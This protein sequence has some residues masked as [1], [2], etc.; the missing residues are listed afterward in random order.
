MPIQTGTH[1]IADL[2]SN[3]FAGEL[4][5]PANVDAINEAVQRDLAIHNQRVTEM[6]GQLADISTERSTAYGTSAEAEAHKKDEFTRGPTQKITRG[7]KVEFPLDAYQFAVGWTADFLRRATVQD[8]ALRTIAARQAHLKRIQQDLKE[9]LF[10]PT[11]YTYVDRR[12]DGNSLSVKRLLNADSSP[13]PTGPNGESF[14]PATHTHYQAVD[15]TAANAAAKAAALAALVQ[16]VIEHGHAAGLVI[17]ISQSNESEVRQAEDFEPLIY[18]N[19]VPGTN[20]DRAVGVLDVTRLDNRLIGYF[21]GFP[22]WTKPWVPTDY[23][24]ASAT[25]EAG[26]KPLRMRVSTL[27]SEQGLF[28]AGQI[29][30]FPLQAEYMEFVHGFGALTRTNGAVLYMGGSDYVAPTF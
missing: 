5:M 8:M 27:A 6:V 13:I 23:A 4:V 10:G 21:R 29:A 3:R 24:F 30:T 19:I 12:V 18:P 20:A 9:A 28:L 22:V 16:D 1:T 14:N 15:F 2:A 7:G 25:G 17:N 11:N 26:A